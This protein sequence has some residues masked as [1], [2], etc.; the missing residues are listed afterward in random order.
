VAAN[1][2][3]S[4]TSVDPL[5]AQPTSG[6]AKLKNRLRRR[7]SPTAASIYTPIRLSWSTLISARESCS[8]RC[9]ARNFEA[10]GAT[11]ANKQLDGSDPALPPDWP[12]HRRPFPQPHSA[13]ASNTMPSMSKLGHRPGKNLASYQM[14]P[15]SNS[16]W[17]SPRGQRALEGIGPTAVNQTPFWHRCLGQGAAASAISAWPPELVRP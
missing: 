15:R 16:S 12:G 8:Q 13:A 3:R 6:S 17:R 5:C 1:Q 14:H 2:A 4:G 10:S 11:L 9:S 7:G